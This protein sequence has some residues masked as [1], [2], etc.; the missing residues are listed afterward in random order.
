MASNDVVS[1]INELIA[2]SKDGEKGFLEAASLVKDPD[3]KILLEQFSRECGDAARELQECAVSAGG[4]TDNTG[5]AMGAVHREWMNIK[6]R[7]APNNEKAVLQEC[8]R[9]EDHAKAIYAKALRAE[10]PMPIKDVVKKQYN[11]TLQHHDRIRALRDKYEA[12]S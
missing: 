2:T 9:G 1:I 11:G 10:M 5:S 12:V 4:Y 6:A 8:E 3:L 7:A